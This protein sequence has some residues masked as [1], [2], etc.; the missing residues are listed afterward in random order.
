[1]KRYSSRRVVSKSLAAEPTALTAHQ[2]GVFR[3]GGMR[4]R[5][6]WDGLRCESPA[7]RESTR[8]GLILVCEWKH[9]SSPLII[10]ARPSRPCEVWVAGPIAAVAYL[11]P[12]NLTCSS[13]SVVWRRRGDSCC[14]QDHHHFYD[15][16]AS[17]MLAAC[18]VC[19]CPRPVPLSPLLWLEL[20]SESRLTPEPAGE[21]IRYWLSFAMSCSR[22][23]TRTGL[24]G[25]GR[26]Y[27]T[28]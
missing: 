19:F 2:G 7:S 6:G 22:R 4:V 11:I 15:L 1:M 18:L 9:P 13:W 27:R 20:Q 5:D 12:P 23:E 28:N 26:W 21:M 14:P 24:T 25:E 8:T 16:A 3:E 17:A 10:T